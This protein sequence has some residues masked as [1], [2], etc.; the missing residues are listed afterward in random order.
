MTRIAA[1]RGVLPEHRYPQGQI[2]EAFVAGWGLTGTKKALLERL[3]TAVGVRTRSLALPI[4]GY[5]ALEGFGG[6]NDAYITRSVELGSRALTEALSDA[7]L[8]PDDVDLILTVSTTGL[9]APSIDARIAANVGLRTDVR[10]VPVFGLGCVGGAAGLARVHDHLRGWPGHVAVLLSVELCSLTLQRH[11][12]TPANLVATALFGDG[13]A[14]VVVCGAA[15]ALPGTAS[16]R[17]TRSRLYPDSGHLMGW[18]V[19]GDGFGV[20]LDPGIP[21]MVRAHLADDVRTFLAAHDLTPRDITTWI[22]HPGG[23]K[24]IDAV[25]ETLDLDP[26]ALALTRT[27]LQEKGNLSSAS[28]LHVLADTLA[29]SPPSGGHAVLLALGPGFCAELV[30][31]DW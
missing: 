28:V 3:H 29:A 20:M 13:A 10:R 27:S 7:G 25:V 23:P 18:N 2:T 12:L 21:D 15:H 24:I 11:D 22:C 26:E 9:A 1:V 8:A 17:A 6:A 31:L 16:V 19:S 30:L 4:G 5:A 14:A